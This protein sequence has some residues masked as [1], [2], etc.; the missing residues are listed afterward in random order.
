MLQLNPT[1]A[2]CALCCILTGPVLAQNAP[3]AESG[4]TIR[5]TVNEVALDLVVRDK[6]GRLV[7]NLKPGDVEI[8]ED[9]VRQDIRSFRLVSNGE[10]PAPPATERQPGSLT[11]E[12]IPLRSVNLVCIVFH[13]LDSQTRKWAVE[14]AQEFI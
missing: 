12:P 5:A 7:K 13:N 6:K 4:P 3:Q 10:A 2:W 11:V 9:G 14:A 8:Y 1:V